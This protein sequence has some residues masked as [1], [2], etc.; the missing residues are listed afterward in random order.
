MRS[1]AVGQIPAR[2]RNTVPRLCS[3]D[4]P[5]TRTDRSRIGDSALSLLRLL[6]QLL[7]RPASRRWKDARELRARQERWRSATRFANQSVVSLRVIFGLCSM[8]RGR[9]ARGTALPVSWSARANTREYSLLCSTSC[10]LPRSRSRRIADGL[11]SDAAPMCEP[12][13]PCSRPRRP[14]VLVHSAAGRHRARAVHPKR[15]L[16]RPEKPRCDWHIGL[17]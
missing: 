2:T 7:T 8:M 6:Q 12:R 16:R 17:R 13:A 11:M 9:T 5:S 15:A 4:Y 1:C 10:V 14:T 3:D